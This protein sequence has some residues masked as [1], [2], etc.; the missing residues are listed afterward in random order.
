MTP[1]SGQISMSS[2][3]SEIMQ[4]G[5]GQVALRGDAGNRLGLGS[6]A[7]LRLTDL[8]RSYGATIT[9]G[10][11]NGEYGD[12]YGY[13]DGLHGTIDDQVILSN[14]S[15]QQNVTAVISFT[16]SGQ[17]LM[18]MNVQF[19]NYTAG[20]VNILAT[21][22]TQRTITSIV[23][24][25]TSPGI[26][27]LYWDQSGT[28]P[29]SGTFTIGLRFNDGGA[30]DTGG[31]GGGGAGGGG[32]GGGQQ[33]G[34]GGGC[35][36][37]HDTEV[38][39]ADLSKKNI[40]QIQV[41]DQILSYN[42]ETQQ[43]ET[44]EVEEL[45]TRVNRM[46]YKYTLANGKEI[47][48]SY[49]HPFFVVGKGYCSMNPALT[50]NGYKSLTNVQMVEVGDNFVDKDNNSIQVDEIVRIDHFDTVYTFNN[51]FKTSPNFYADG[52]LVY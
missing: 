8:Y 13:S 44:N 4:A 20:N 11:Y 22:N 24:P 28:L 51:K 41:G 21:Q 47:R 19:A 7:N 33:N 46:M 23:N 5:S 12:Q 2:L 39:M 52:V 42:P 26:A 27:E 45:I 48:A 6:G 15:V 18:G 50:M 29:S 9:S 32:G 1:I 43:H 37:T 38:T 25:N 30:I 14:V 40:N 3:R 31:G 35:C 10:I 17:E 49:D 16:S 36:F 34:G